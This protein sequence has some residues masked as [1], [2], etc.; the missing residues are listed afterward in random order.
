M[1]LFIALGIIIVVLIGLAMKMR[2]L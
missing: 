2:T 1:G